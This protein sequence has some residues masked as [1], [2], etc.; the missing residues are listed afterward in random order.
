MA[1]SDKEIEEFRMQRINVK[2][3]VILGGLIATA[4]TL[5]LMLT[6]FDLPE[7][8]T[9]STKYLPKITA[10]LGGFQYVS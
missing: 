8:I 3:N 6:N 1:L 10:F 7:N 5:I 9:Y 2:S 4:L